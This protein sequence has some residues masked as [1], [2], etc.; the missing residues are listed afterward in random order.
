MMRIGLSFIISAFFCL[1]IAA[2]PQRASAAPTAADPCVACHTDL[3]KVLPQNHKPVKGTG[4]SS[5]TKCHA[6]GESGEAEVNAF[7]TKVH[8]AHFAQKQTIECTACHSY[9][10]GK[11]F[12][13][14]GQS[15]SWGAPT[16]SDFAAMKEDFASWA[17]SAFTD[18][19][20]AKA[21]VD[22]AGCHG[23]AMTSAD[24]SVDNQRCLTCHGPLQKLV[25]KTRN[26]EFPKRNPHSSHL[27]DDIAC[28]TCHHAHAAAAVYCADCHKL[29]KMPIMGT[30]K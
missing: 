17:G 21:S 11:S 1:G 7:S 23:K 29:W 10:A 12:G 26:A 13:L 16:D 22:C 3:S 19:L 27:G 18:N 2:L 20:H 15:H 14:I 5:C 4:F 6:T 25:D 24:A 8:L 30:G 28:T 9:V